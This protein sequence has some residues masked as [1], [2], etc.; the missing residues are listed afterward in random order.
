[1]ESPEIPGSPT[2]FDGFEVIV[3]PSVGDLSSIM[4]DFEVFENSVL[5]IDQRI[6]FNTRHLY[7]GSELYI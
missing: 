5:H 2:C 6:R 1:M 3:N 4:G 7:C